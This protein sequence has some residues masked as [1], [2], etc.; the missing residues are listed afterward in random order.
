LVLSI[1][2]Q[3]SPLG[4]EADLI[5]SEHQ[6]KAEGKENKNKGQKKEKKEK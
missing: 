3:N 1:R 4:K 6:A 2:S 5:F